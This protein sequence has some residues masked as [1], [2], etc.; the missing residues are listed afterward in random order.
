MKSP[1]IILLLSICLSSISCLKNSSYSCDYDACSYVAPSAEIQ[2]IE[3]YLSTNSITNATKH[4]SGMYYRILDPGSGASTNVCAVVSVQ[5][6]GMLANGTVFEQS[7]TPYVAELGSLITG[8]KVGIPLI[9]E[10]GKIILYIP[11]SLGYG[12][13][14]APPT[15]PANSML[16]FEVTLVATSR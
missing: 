10:G 7:T 1:A 15:I 12:A 16:I 6:K 14:G 5:Y 9:K 11:P 13:A 8:W 2:Q 3:A 4:C